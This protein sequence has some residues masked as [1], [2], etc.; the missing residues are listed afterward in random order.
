[1]NKSALL[2]RLAKTRE[3]AEEANLEIILQSQV[4]ARLRNQGLDANQADVVLKGLVNAEQRH[5]T[6]MA[7][8]LDQLDKPN[9]C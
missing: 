1:M 5:L 8:L 3:R 9:P 7:W 2:E 4:I 6:E